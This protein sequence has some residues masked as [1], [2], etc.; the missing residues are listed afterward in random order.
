MANVVMLVHEEN[1]RFGASF[2]DFP[3]CTTVAGDPD[4]LLAKAADALAFHVAGLVE[5]GESM[6]PVRSQSEI[7]N[8]PAFQADRKE[9]AFIALIPVELPGRTVRVNITLNESA[10]DMIDRAAEKVGESRSGFL[11]ASALKRVRELQP[12]G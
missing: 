5:D 12:Q 1:G 4:T 11:V 10:L 9:A 3:G 8:D 7:W 6:P 2:P